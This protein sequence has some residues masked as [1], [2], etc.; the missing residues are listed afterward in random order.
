MAILP[1]GSDIRRISDPSGTGLGTK[2]D[3]WVYPYPTRFYYGSGTDLI[4]YPRVPDGYP[5]IV[6]LDF[7]PTSTV[8]SRPPSTTHPTAIPPYLMM[9]LIW[10]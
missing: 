9:L 3:P 2:F 7:Q 1:A 6:I 10:F 8:A 5:K 4:S